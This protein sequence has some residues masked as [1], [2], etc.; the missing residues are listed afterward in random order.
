ML[1]LGI[2]HDRKNMLRVHRRQL[3]DRSDPFYIPEARFIELFRL[4]KD[5]TIELLEEISPYMKDGIR[6]TFIPKNIRLAAALHFYATGSFQRDIGQDFV[7][8]MSKSM[9]S[10]VLHEITYIIQNKLMPKYIKFATSA[11][12]KNRIRER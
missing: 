4:S 9:I 1:A 8:P 10:R 2:I 5:S 7:C 12:E 3:R 11:D 6:M